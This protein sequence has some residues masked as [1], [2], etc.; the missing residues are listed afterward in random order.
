MDFSFNA[1]VQAVILSASLSIDAFAAAFAY[2]CAGVKIPFKSVQVINFTCSFMLGASLF[3]GMYISR[4]IT[5]Q[6]G[7]LACF[8]IL[9]AIGIFKLLQNIF[10][11]KPDS[12][13]SDKS[14]K[15]GAKTIGAAEAVVLAAGLSIDGLAVGFG[16]ALG[17]S[18]AA[19]MLGVSLITDMAAVMLGCGLGRRLA[20]RIKL[21]LSWLGGAVIIA[22][23]A[24][25]LWV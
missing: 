19:V 5:E 16:A 13:N 17:Q 18:N 7:A 4:L 2:G 21:N 12:D 11:K 23:A 25:K 3:A 9:S 14:E 8:A 24:T 1:C 15:S 6:S 20:K 22:L 10:A